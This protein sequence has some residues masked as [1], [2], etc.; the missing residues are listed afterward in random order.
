MRIRPSPLEDWL[1]D[2]Y[3]QATYDLACSGVASW[4][5]GSLRALTGIA[6][7]DLDQLVFDDGPSNGSLELR[8]AIADRYYGG[9]AG[10]VMVTHGSS[11]A[12]FTAVATLLEPGDEVV[13]FTPGYHA[14]I[15]VADAVG[16]KV[17]ACPLAMDE[18]PAVDFGLLEDLVSRRPKMIIANFPNNPTGATLTDGELRLLVGL[19]ESS[20]AYL[21]W[22]GAFAELTF[23][24]GPLTDPL[25]LYER[26]VS[27]GTLSKA[28]GLPGLRVGWCAAD[29]AV[30][31]RFLPWRDRTTIAV[32]PLNALIAGHVMRN[33]D[34]V[35][36]ARRAELEA[37]RALVA[38]WL[39]E[40]PALVAGAV[41]PGGVTV[42]PRLV[43]QASA[44]PLCTALLARHGVLV[45]PGNCFGHE[46]RFRLGFG[47]PA[48]SLRH[49]LAVLTEAVQTQ[50]DEVPGDGR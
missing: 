8:E 23:L 17:L 27:F 12:I 7:E 13:V 29:P 38:R 34:A 10:S 46:S 3:F 20:G 9:R 31:D 36:G 2:R 39:G 11:E 32:S 33:A 14:L 6:A 21:L 19:A 42:F 5:L 44:V 45:A 47:C 18:S 37:N 15:D 28:F 26:C 48:R 16:A 25:R 40:Q 43:R 1:R 30:L 41:G 50:E 22:D 49:G 4:S 35:L 24:A